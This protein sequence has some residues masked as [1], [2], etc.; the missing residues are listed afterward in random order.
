MV[1]QQVHKEGKTTTIHITHINQN[2]KKD[3]IEVESDLK[4][5]INAWNVGIGSKCG[6]SK[7]V[8]SQKNWYFNY[9]QDGR[10]SGG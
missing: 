6:K 9:Y 4:D 1:P 2:S 10:K 5:V 8:M 7:S 3:K